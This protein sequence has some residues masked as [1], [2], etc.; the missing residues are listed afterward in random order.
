MFFLAIVSHEDLLNGNIVPS[1]VLHWSRGNSTNRSPWR[2][3]R[4]NA[5]PVSTPKVLVKYPF[6]N[7]IMIDFLS[8]YRTR[9]HMY[10][11]NK[12]SSHKKSQ[13]YYPKGALFWFECNQYG[14]P[15]GSAVFVKRIPDAAIIGVDEGKKRLRQ[16]LLQKPTIAKLLSQEPLSTYLLQSGVKPKLYQTH[17]KTSNNN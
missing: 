11:P 4:A 3:Y 14:D 16:S 12:K 5:P 8:H 6:G 1:Y 13:K 2:V 9:D 17:A 10:Y 7:D 15:T